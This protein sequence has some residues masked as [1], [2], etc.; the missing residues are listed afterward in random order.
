MHQLIKSLK[1]DF[2]YL[3]F[4]AGQTFSW[5]PKSDTVTYKEEVSESKLSTW[6]LLHEV[7]HAILAH[8]TYES[9]F[10]LVLLEA[11]AWHKAIEIAKNYQVEIDK[12]HVED[13]IDTYRDWLHKRSACPICC[14]QSLQVSPKLY[15][16]YNCGSSWQVSAARFCRPYRRLS[17]QKI[18]E[19]V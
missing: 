8:K 19:P 13:C 15:R 2:P 14:R 11:T 4:E 3:K 16:C 6:S 18:K 7:G 9:D 12:E 1:Q 10:E 5:S 17:P